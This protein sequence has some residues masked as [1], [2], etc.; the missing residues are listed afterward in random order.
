MKKNLLILFL[1][2]QVAIGIAQSPYQLTR[3][4]DAIIGGS[5]LT[6][7]GIDL[8]LNANLEPLTHEQILELDA[9]QINRF[10]RWAT[11]QNSSAAGHRSDIGQNAPIIAAMGSTLLY[12]CISKNGGS[13]VIEFMTIATIFLE[14]N[15]VNSGITEMVKSSVKRTRPYAY[16]PERSLESKLSK[17]TRKSFFSGHTSASAA[18]SFFLAK[19][20]SDYYPESK[21]KPAVWAVAAAVPAW[22]G[23]ERVLAGKHFPTDVIVG[24]LVG[25]SCGYIIPHLHR[26]EMKG[27]EMGY[28]GNGLALTYSF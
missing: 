23:L 10:D 8:I 2:F 18:N 16:D 7:A 6:L 26:K 5:I 12:P 9:S 4:T 3:K 14:T 22:T 17:S 20:F 19:V 25:A 11:K 28:T 27:L 13:R 1:L 21:W 15:L 24:Y